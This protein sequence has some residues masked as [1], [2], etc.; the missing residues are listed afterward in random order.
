MESRGS[1]RPTDNRASTVGACAPTVLLS[2][3]QG[4]EVRDG[5]TTGSQRRSSNVRRSFEIDSAPHWK[6]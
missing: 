5:S 4:I 2:L 6:I 1:A 3:D